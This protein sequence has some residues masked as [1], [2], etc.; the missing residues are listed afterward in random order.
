MRKLANL[1]LL[2]FVLSALTSIADQL[3]QLFLS[4]RIFTGLT[5]L[6]WLACLFSAAIVYLGLA[7][8]RHLP[9]VILLPLFLWLF[10]TL[11]GHWPLEN[12]GG[13]YFQLYIAC[14]Q[15]LFII[16]LLNLNR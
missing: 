2:L 10:W 8:N 3:A 12:I 4:A 7:F 6:I 9:K 14:G 16:L 1:F 5:Q 15:L 11:V 13:Q